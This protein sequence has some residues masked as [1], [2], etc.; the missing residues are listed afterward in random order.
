VREVLH[1]TVTPRIRPLTQWWVDVLFTGRQIGWVKALPLPRKPVT[2]DSRPKV[3]EAKE[4]FPVPDDLKGV[5][6]VRRD[7][8]RE[9]EAF[10]RRPL[11]VFN[12]VHIEAVE[13]LLLHGWS[14]FLPSAVR[15]L[16]N[17]WRRAGLLERK[18][19]PT[20]TR[21]ADGSAGARSF[22][23]EVRDRAKTLG[24]SAVG[25]APYVPVYTFAETATEEL[26]PDGDWSVIVCLV[27][28]D[29]AATQTIPSAKAERAAFRAYN[30][31]VPGINGLTDFIQSQ[32]Y[33]A[34][35]LNQ[36]GDVVLIHYAV[37]AGLG[38]LGLNGQLLTPQAGSRVRLGAVVTNA[39]VEHGKPQD[40]GIEKLCD[41]C[42]LCV[43]RCP[44]GAIPKERREYRGVTKIKIKPERCYPTMVQ[45]HG[46]SVCMKVC[47]VQRYGL[48]SVLDHYDQTGGEILGKGSDELEGFTWPLDAVRYGPGSKP[49]IDSKMLSPTGWV[50][51]PER[52][53]PAEQARE[54]RTTA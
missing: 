34:L 23:E 12:R 50:F 36:D 10:K 27:E 7:R 46:C 6:G 1:D 32:G 26:A 17:E 48:R 29:W 52:M 14:F 49:P 8:E 25:A 28:Q 33:S 9:K 5:V 13:Y 15:M 51:E 22:T 38:Q 16:R 45:T 53:G 21:A 30:E 54:A 4:S 20:A 18:G 2:T 41:S 43:R 40:F 35:P 3:W 19:A 42:Q 47:P 11:K 37:D 31:L 44:P 39:P 24:L